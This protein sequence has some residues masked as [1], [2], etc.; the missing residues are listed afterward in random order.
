M[1]EFLK[2][3]YAEVLRTLRKLDDR[4]CY[5]GADESPRC[6]DL[7]QA[8]RNL[9]QT[10]SPGQG[11]VLGIDVYRYSQYGDLEQALIPLVLRLIYE[12]A[13]C[14]CLRQER[15]MFQRLL[16][17][18]SEGVSARVAG[19]RLRKNWVDTGDGGYQLL[20]TPLHALLFALN[21]ETDVRSYN[22]GHFFP[23]LRQVVGALSLR[24]CITK[25]S[26]FRFEG[27]LY[28]TA[29]I[30]NS[31]ILSRDSLNRC[32]ID[33]PTFDWFTDRFNGI[34]GLEFSSLK[35]IAELPEFTEYSRDY[36]AKQ[37]VIIP[38]TFGPSELPI[39]LV[40]T[41]KIGV[42]EAKERTFAIYNLYVQLVLVLTENRRAKGS[43]FVVG[44]GNLNTTGL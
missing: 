28:G 44:L 22:S 15:Y 42:F 24:Y 23:K 13:S 14:D 29:I 32:L 2:V 8:L 27:N 30:N 20:E 37:N 6:D 11:A 16:R 1:S 34:E 12:E 3:S 33:Q 40:A 21:F 41:Q 26:L 19:A 25:E 35:E 7:R 36:M 9:Y 10:S 31:R 43:L 18:P 39:H 4:D 38:A 17:N 5:G